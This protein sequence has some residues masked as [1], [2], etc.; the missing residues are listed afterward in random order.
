MHNICKIELNIAIFVLSKVNLL[1]PEFKL[2]LMIISW[3]LEIVKRFGRYF[4]NWQNSKSKFSNKDFVQSHNMCWGVGSA[5]TTTDFMSVFINWL[6]LPVVAILN[7]LD[8]IS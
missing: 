7:G 3:K 2:L 6:C 1:C 8:S 4:A 5:T